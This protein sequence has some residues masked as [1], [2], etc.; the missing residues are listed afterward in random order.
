MLGNIDSSLRPIIIRNL[1]KNPSDTELWGIR[2]MRL[3]FSKVL[4]IT[5]FLL[6]PKI[7]FFV[8]FGKFNRFLNGSKS[9]NL[10][11]FMWKNNITGPR[12][13]P[14]WSKKVG[15]IFHRSNQYPLHFWWT[16]CNCVSANPLFFHSAFHHLFSA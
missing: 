3:L 6:F 13:D 7:R 9:E 14:L 1:W 5:Q 4:V 2:T 12:C 16:C 8:C 10:K 11:V 15:A